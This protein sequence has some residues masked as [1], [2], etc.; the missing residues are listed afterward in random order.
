MLEHNLRVSACVRTVVGTMLLFLVNLE[1]MKS[2][3]VPRRCRTPGWIDIPCIAH[4]I[5]AGAGSRGSLVS[6]SFHKSL[7]S[8]MTIKTANVM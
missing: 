1:L 7:E 3:V 2:M 8:I 5:V 6:L 4:L